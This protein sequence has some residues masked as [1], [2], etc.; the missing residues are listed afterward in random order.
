MIRFISRCS[1]LYILLL[2]AAPLSMTVDRA[3][4]EKLERKPPRT[5]FESR[6]SIFSK[7]FVVQHNIKK[8]ENLSAS[9]KTPQ[10]ESAAEEKAKNSSNP[11]V[12][13]DK[14]K[15][16]ALDY[17]SSNPQ[18]VK[19][20]PPEQTPNVRVNAETPSSIQAM[21]VAM[22]QGDRELAKAYGGQFVRYMQNYFFELNEI[23]SVIG[24]VLK[25]QEIID[26]DDWDG[27]GVNINY[28]LAKSRNEVGSLIKPTHDVA[29]S[30]I[31]PDKQQKVEILY[32]FSTSCSWCRYMTPDVER[33]WRMVKDDPRVKMTALTIGNPPAAWIDEYRSYS[34][35]TMPIFEGSDVAKKLDIGFVPAVVVITPS[36]EHA[37]MKTGQQN[38]EHLY[39]FVRTA[40][41]LP[42]KVTKKFQKI[43]STPIGAAE[44]A[45]AQSM[46]AKAGKN[47]RGRLKT[48]AAKRRVKR[49]KVELG[50]F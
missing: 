13:K 25:E 35:M 11:A 20:L 9:S 7:G 37:Y 26:E 21:I 46:Q 6:P 24:D 49:V 29:M 45:H 31:E 48:P 30:R 16:L 17:V 50:T 27:V 18:D 47:V 43:A 40:Q 39:E 15:R 8:V 14:L 33:L 42:A 1:C 32:F 34:E 12:N 10:K 28:H 3:S 36:N 5:A 2:L 44:R 23:V 41:G 22:R 19:I 38:F 4:A